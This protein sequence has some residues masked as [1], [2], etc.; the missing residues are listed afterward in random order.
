MARSVYVVYPLA[1][2]NKSITLSAQSKEP[3]SRFRITSIRMAEVVSLIPQKLPAL[4]LD[5]A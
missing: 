2:I 4:K 5:L 3:Y 1:A